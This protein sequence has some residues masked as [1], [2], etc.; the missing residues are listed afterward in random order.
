MRLRTQRKVIYVT[1]GLTVLA[2]VGGFAAAQLTGPGTTNNQNGFTFSAPADT[3]YGGTNPTA[4]LVVTM[5]P[6]CTA[7]GGDV[8]AASGVTTVSV[9][10]TGQTICQ[11]TDNDFFEEYTFTSNAVGTAAVTDTFTISC[12]G[13]ADEQVTTSFSGLTAGTSTVTTNI[14]FELGGSATSTSCII[15]VTGS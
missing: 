5:A 13:F 10:L 12:S 11:T 3:I 15:G 8:E 7:S 6:T 2:L 1:M 4:N 14:Y 9:Y